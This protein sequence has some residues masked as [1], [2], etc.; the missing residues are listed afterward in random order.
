[1]FSLLAAFSAPDGIGAMPSFV[2][3]CFTF[4]LRDNIFNACGQAHT[5][6]PEDVNTSIDGAN[7]SEFFWFDFHFMSFSGSVWLRCEILQ[8]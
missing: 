3:T 7:R 2:S 8:R 6:D 4:A 5:S 1:M